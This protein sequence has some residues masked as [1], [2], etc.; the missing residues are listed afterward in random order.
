MLATLKPHLPF[1]ALAAASA[2]V[3]LY[4]YRELHRARQAL[5]APTTKDPSPAEGSAAKAKKV[6]FED[7]E[8]GEPGA[9]AEPSKPS[10]PS[11]PSGSDA[12]VST[13]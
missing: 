12:F 6:R 8:P 13:E 2:L 9:S 7:D 3:I 1:I 11:T 5:A 4:L 10:K